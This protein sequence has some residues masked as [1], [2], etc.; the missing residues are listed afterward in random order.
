[1]QEYFK[2][3]SG[4]MS[5]R[6]I[7]APALFFAVLVAPVAG[8]QATLTGVV[9]DSSGRPLA[10]AEVMIE[11][12]RK[13]A[14]TDEEGRYRIPDVPT[15]ASLVQARA[16]GYQSVASVV[17]LSP[18]ET[19]QTDFVLTR[20]A[21]Q[22]D[23]VQVKDR[24]RGVGSGLA[25][26]EER[27]RLGVGKFFDSLD[28]KRYEDR[29]VVDVFREIP[30]VKIGP[31]ALCDRR[32]MPRG[33]DTNPRKRVLLNIRGGSSGCP[34]GI[35]LDGATLYRA[36]AGGGDIDWPRTI[37]VNDLPVRH[38]VAV[39]VYR[40][41]SEAPIEYGGPSANCGVIVMWTRRS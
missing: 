40:S 29:Q 28:L 32:G 30:G 31:T 15:G 6:T 18:N 34:M 13:R 14:V 23:T 38:L 10:R 5:M 41:A 8:A 17:T 39:E 33:C 36:E 20:V 7:W 2:Q 25:A 35:V 37:D 19:R 21:T 4:E 27:R 26:F 22:L 24:M 1:M 3:A 11:A 9:R 12:R 16:L